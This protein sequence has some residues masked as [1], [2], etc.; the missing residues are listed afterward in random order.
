MPLYEY[1]CAR[2]KQRF[3]MLRPLRRMDDRADC[4]AGHG[5]GERVLST[6][7]AFTQ[8]GD[9]DAAALGGSP[10]AGCSTG[11]CS[12]CGVLN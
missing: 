6:F 10:C 1:Y 5:A 8:G 3:E 9:G 12:T 11:A 4:P 2:C 7:A